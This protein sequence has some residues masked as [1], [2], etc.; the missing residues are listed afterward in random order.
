MFMGRS[1]FTRVTDVVVADQP[2]LQG[3]PLGD[4]AVH[5]VQE[6]EQAPFVELHQGDRGDG[7]GHGIDAED[8]VVGHRRLLL[9][10]P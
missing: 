8:G 1:G 4:V 3:A 6:L 7:L 2:D 10:G 5:R 9:R